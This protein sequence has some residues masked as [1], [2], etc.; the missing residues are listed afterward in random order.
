MISDGNWFCVHWTAEQ[1]FGI[2][3]GEAVVLCWI[4]F[5]A[6]NVLKCEFEL[7]HKSPRAAQWNIAAYNRPRNRIVNIAW[8]R[9]NRHTHLSFDFFHAK[10]LFHIYI[11]V[12]MVNWFLDLCALRSN[13][14][15]KNDCVKVVLSLFWLMKNTFA[16]SCLF[17]RKLQHS[18]L[19]T[20]IREPFPFLYVGFRRLNVISASFGIQARR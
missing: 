12:R 20:L 18:E 14:W 4:K 15:H 13:L 16:A 5:G 19:F 6:E 10:F 17:T 8:V 9:Q 1:K 7:K 3:I 2:Q 11:T